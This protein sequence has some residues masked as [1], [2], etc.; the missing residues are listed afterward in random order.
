LILGIT[1]ERAFPTAKRKK[2]KTISVGVRPCQAHAQAADKYVAMSPDYLQGSSGKP[3]LPGKHQEN[4]N[5][6]TN[7][8]I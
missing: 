2:G 3:W 1:K 8:F 6:K 5:V 7:Y 4:S